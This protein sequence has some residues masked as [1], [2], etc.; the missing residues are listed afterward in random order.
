MACAMKN[1]PFFVKKGAF[2]MNSGCSLRQPRPADQACVTLGS[3][4]YV[5]I[6]Q[7]TFS[8]LR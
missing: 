8:F 5:H 6:L 4:L 1:A 2:F 7:V 3:T